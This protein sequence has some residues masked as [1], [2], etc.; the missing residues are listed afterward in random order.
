MASGVFWAMALVVACAAMF[1]CCKARGCA[2]SAEES[3]TTMGTT[4]RL[5]IGMRSFSGSRTEF[6]N[7]AVEL[8]TGSG[9]LR[10]GGGAAG[11]QCY[12]DGEGREFLSTA[13]L[14]ET[15]AAIEQVLARMALIE[16]KVRDPQG[17]RE[18]PPLELI[19]FWVEGVE[20][21]LPNL[22][23]PNPIL[24][25]ERWAIAS[26]VEAGEEA[27]LDAVDKGTETKASVR[28]F[29]QSFDQLARGAPDHS[30][31]IY[32]F[33]AGGLGIPVVH[34]RGGQVGMEMAAVDVPDAFA[35][36]GYLFVV[37]QRVASRADTKPDEPDERSGE[38]A[39][40][41]L[42]GLHAE[43]FVPLE[44]TF[45]SDASLEEQVLL[46]TRAVAGNLSGLQGSAARILVWTA[47]PQSAR[48]L[49][50]VA[51]DSTATLSRAPVDVRLVQEPMSSP[52]MIRVELT[53]SVSR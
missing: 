22:T 3:L 42:S 24:G 8:L 44:A 10:L 21:A 43:S 35:V 11:Y 32:D 15:E 4:R 14:F 34:H 19:L 7:A 50:M 47:T 26:F 9:E 23:L 25:R 45:S 53:A 12:R 40:S 30:G 31:P 51:P 17:R 46:W 52:S 6:L 49:L 16:E 39:A 48:G 29:A 27:L 38:L 1:G 20:T 2:P 36:A 5:V 18:L 13:V 37:A 33:A 41:V 28:R